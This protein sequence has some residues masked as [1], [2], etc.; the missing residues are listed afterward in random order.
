MDIAPKVQAQGNS[1]L[2]FLG[3]LGFPTVCGLDLPTTTF[4]NS[5]P[6]PYSVI[7][8]NDSGRLDS[9]VLF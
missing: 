3:F 5:L 1:V 7:V 4:R 6:V 9:Q 2:L 8:Y